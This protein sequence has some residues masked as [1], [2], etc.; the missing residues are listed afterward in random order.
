MAV[1]EHDTNLRWRGAFLREFADLI[2]DGVGG[3][4]EPGG[5][6]AR[7][8]DGGGAYALAVAVQ[9]THGG[10]WYRITGETDVA[11]AAELSRYEVQALSGILGAVPRVSERGPKVE[12]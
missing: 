7:V 5:S 12:L 4:L 8:W 2:D 10:G 6:G 9:A 11:C 3:G 1:S